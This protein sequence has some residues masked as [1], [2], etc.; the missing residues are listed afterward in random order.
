MRFEFGNIPIPQPTAAAPAQLSHKFH[1]AL[2]LHQQGQPARAQV[3]CEEILKIE[4][5]HFDTLN[6]LGLIA[7]QTN[8]LKRAV[9]LFDRAIAAN[10]NHAPTYCN[11]GY[12]LQESR[13]LEAALASYDRALAIHAAYALAHNNRGNVLRLLGRLEE[14]LASF[15]RAVAISPAFVQPHYN[16][17]LVLVEFQRLEE[18]LASYNQAIALK[19]DYA[20]AYSQRAVVLYLLKQFESAVASYDQ[21]LAINPADSAGWMV[22]GNILKEAK[23]L[24]AALAS[25][26]RAI[27]VDPGNA[28]AYLNRGTAF[29]EQRKFDAAI[30]DYNRAV[31]ISPNFAA[32]YYNRANV[33]R[34]VKNYEAAAESYDTARSM[35]PSI[36]FLPGDCREARM[37]LCDWHEFEADVAR[38]TTG[39]ERGEAVCNPFCAQVLSE[40]ARLQRKAAEIWAREICPPDASLPTIRKLASHEKIRIGYF[41]ADFRIHPVPALAAEMIETHDRSRFDV[42]AFSFGPDTGDEM[43][44]RMERAFERFIDVRDKSDQQIALLARHMELDIAVDL[45][46]FTEDSR[47]NIFALRAA[48]IQVSYLGYLGTMGAEYI[49]YLI[50]DRTI[51][52]VES[53]PHYGEKIIYLPSYQ[54][55]D[56]KRRIADRVFA[57]EELGLPRTGFVFCCFNANYKIIPATF[58][59][60]MR[61]LGRV[62]G[63]VL[64][65]YAH[66][67][68]ASINLRK[69]ARSRGID[70]ERLVFGE[71][72]AI[73]E[74]L[75]RYRAADL[76]LDTLPYNAG[77]TASDALWAGL[78]VLTRVGE[79]FASRMAASLLN[80]IDLPELIT[81]TQRQYED[82][83]VQL[84]TDPLRLARIKQRLA[85]KRLTASLFDTPR[86]TRHLEAAF[87]ELYRRYQS[88]LPKEDL[89]VDQAARMM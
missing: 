81:Y 55:N 39:V 30:A 70:P 23:Q 34:C 29:Y 14:A 48:P 58:D 35:D 86:F 75:A 20:D 62:E 27:A 59:G 31:A 28:D 64:F 15:D 49:D 11:R 82:L 43:R 87:T 6:L 72:L 45:G 2:A 7:G 85:E 66:N 68:A 10:P 73:P 74:Y 4:P 12:A 78:P 52:P 63:S 69:E 17:G 77:T 88:D 54:A 33:L 65:L 36:R 16:R 41:S 24:D 50:A 83:A 18:A 38:I 13:Q 3:V 89:H 32:A 40:S 71:R 67:R 8:D 51:I 60:W 84:A 25:Y 53:R 61:I 42:T 57:R 22:R 46:G 1:Q 76:F 19:R 9:E 56:S 5:D 80:A 47:A 44:K 26:D 79:A 37:H 21:A